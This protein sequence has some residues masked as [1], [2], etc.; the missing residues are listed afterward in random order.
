MRKE[1]EPTAN[2]P[3][4]GVS[5]GLPPALRTETPSGF[6]AVN[7]EN[8]RHTS[9]RPD[10][11]ARPSI[12]DPI[13][14]KPIVSSASPRSSTRESDGRNHGWRPDER[15]RERERERRDHDSETSRS[16]GTNMTGKR[17]RDDPASREQDDRDKN[18]ATDEHE[19]PKRRA[20]ESMTGS[21]SPSVHE[22]KPAPEGTPPTN[23]MPPSKRRYVILMSHFKSFTTRNEMKA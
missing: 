7:S 6:T 15:E 13:D 4:N 21:K 19:S 16:G 17:K 18:G 3:Q 23:D 1:S 20:T 8:Q 5:H 12:S 14:N 2:S 22:P 11:S 10:A 9:F